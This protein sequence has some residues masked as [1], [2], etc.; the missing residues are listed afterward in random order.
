MAFVSL[1]GALAAPRPRAAAM[2]GLWA[3]LL[4]LT[5]FQD[6]TWAATLGLA[7][8][9]VLGR[10]FTGAPN[11]DLGRRDSPRSKLIRV[12][13]FSG[14]FLLAVSPQIVVWKVLYGSWFS[15]PVPYLGGEGGSFGVLP[16]HLWGVL[17]S[18]RGGF[19][20]WHP[21]LMIGIGGLCMVAFGKGNAVVQRGLA[22]WSLLGIGLQ[23]ILI[24]SWSMWWG[25]A[26][27][28]NRFFISSYPFLAWGLAAALE[29]ISNRF[30]TWKTALLVLILIAWNFGLLIQYGTEMIS[31]EEA[32]SWLTVIGNQFSKVPAWIMDRF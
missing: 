5:R 29:R 15:G 27:F 32:E 6:M 11:V 12:A 18:E 10:G 30:G 7:Q 25:G 3:G 31:R 9:L 19:L 16:A 13:A 28:G 1:N 17:F 23:V 26:S 4:V 21:I 14:L 2:T 22:R 8:I 24:A 20:A